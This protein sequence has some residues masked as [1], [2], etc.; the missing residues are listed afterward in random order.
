MFA[1]QPLSPYAAAA[2]LQLNGEHDFLFCIFFVKDIHY[3]HFKPIG[4][5]R[6]RLVSFCQNWNGVG[7]LWVQMG[8]R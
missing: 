3:E 1:Q 8:S 6:T 4:N 2:A 5:P 7:Y